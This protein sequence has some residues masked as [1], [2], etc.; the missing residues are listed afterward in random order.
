MRDAAQGTHYMDV[1][2]RSQLSVVDSLG[3]AMLLDARGIHF[4]TQNCRYD[5]SILVDGLYDQLARLSGEPCAKGGLQKRLG[6]VD[7]EQTLYLHDQ[8][9]K[10]V[11]RTI[12]RWPL[13][14]IGDSDC[15]NIQVDEAT[16]RWLFS[17]TFPGSDS[18]MSRCQT[19]VRQHIGKFLFTDPF[20]GSCP[21]LSTVVT[22][23]ETS[24]Q[25]F[26]NQQSLR[27]ELYRLPGLDE[28]AKVEAEM[29]IMY[30]EQL[31]EIL[32]QALSKHRSQPPGAPGALQQYV[33]T[34][35]RQRDLAEDA[36]Q[37]V[38]AQDL[39]LLL[40]FR[41][42]A[43]T[44]PSLASLAA[45]PRST[46]PLNLTIQ[47]PAQQACCRGGSLAAR[48]PGGTCAYPDEALIGD[49]GCV[50]GR[51]ASGAS[52]AFAYT[53]CANMVARCASDADCAQ[54]GHANHL[55]LTGSCCGG[56]VCVD[57]L[58]CS[59]NGTMLVGPPPGPA[60]A[61]NSLQWAS[62]RETT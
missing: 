21:D 29:A 18:G 44:M 53:E 11:R 19:A 49:S 8:C 59:Q 25:D 42:G 32:K 14:R 20:A 24:S 47:D 28:A 4:S 12:R 35:D 17:C 46:R 55:C 41:A 48:G 43:S 3:N 58:E 62:R 40:S 57:A 6:D 51:T 36:C 61:T 37:E 10:P 23:L 15:N 1:S 33:A 13:L 16:G 27:T 45:A 54:A 34:Y 26:L 39:P 2:N 52:I 50:C 38:H 60:A 22:T 30:Y 7:F 5:V 31:W 56:G 9:G